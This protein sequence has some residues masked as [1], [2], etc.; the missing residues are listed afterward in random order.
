[1]AVAVYI[2]T[3]VFLFI[4]KL[5]FPKGNSIATIVRK[6]YGL[7]TL[8]KIRKFEKLDYRHRKTELDLGFLNECK[9]RSIIPKFL[10]FKTAN[11]HLQ[12]S[13][14]YKQCQERFLLEEIS[15]KET[16]SRS[17][18]IQLD[19]LKTELSITLSR[20]D[21]VHI[22]T[23]CTGSNDK[24]I[25]ID[26]NRQH[27]KLHYLT[28]DE[29]IPHDPSKV[30]FNYS[31]HS[32]TDDEKRLLSLGLNFALPPTKLNYASFLAPFEQ[33]YSN[34][35]DMQ[36]YNCNKDEFKTFLKNIA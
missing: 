35:K 31:S 4:A 14:T 5:R 23:L 24:K 10:R 22:I 25:R 3:L 6:R 32:L 20:F 27:C 33:L 36:T 34:I 1:M 26:E 18:K 19:S 28:L 9:D 29:Q 30:I 7:N 15:S 13:N 16:L 8:A 2:Y 21:F 17:T 12:S 11:S